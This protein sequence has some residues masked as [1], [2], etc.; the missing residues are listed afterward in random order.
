MQEERPYILISNDDGYTAPG[1]NY[2][3]DT[4]MPMADIIVVAPDSPRSG[5]GCCITPN[6]PLTCK[7]MHREPGLEVY[8]CSGTPVD[9]VKVALNR[10]VRRRPDLIIGGINHGDN[11]SVNAH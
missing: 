6:V 4:L 7:L 3:I 8:A 1:I 5:A 11:S 2:L 9:C 10:F